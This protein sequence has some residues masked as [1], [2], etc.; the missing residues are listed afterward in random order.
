MALINH[1]KDPA[2]EQT[3]AGYPEVKAMGTTFI[4]QDKEKETLRR[5]AE[6]VA[7]IASR[8]IMKEKAKLWTAHNDLKTDFLGRKD[9]G[10]QGY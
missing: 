9:E 10:R 7:E 4:F 5:L 1:K 8:P 2:T 6:H 3:A